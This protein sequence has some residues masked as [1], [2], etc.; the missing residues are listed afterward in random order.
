MPTMKDV[1][2]L[3]GVS[4]GTVSNVLNGS[5]GVSIDKIR[6]VEEAVKAL[7]Y[8]PNALARNLKTSSSGRIDVLLPNVTDAANACLYESIAAAA[9]RDGYGVY[10]QL[11]GDSAEREAENLDRAHMYNTDGVILMTCR[12]ERPEPFLPLVD[13]GL[14]LV[15]VQREI[16]SDDFAF[17][18]LDARAVLSADMQSRLASGVTRMAIVTGPR[19]NSFEAACIDAYCGALFKAGIDVR[20]RNVEAV[21]LSR[22]AAMRAAIRLLACDEPPEIIYC[23]CQTLYDGVRCALTLAGKTKPLPRVVRFDAEDWTRQADTNRL[24]LPYA[25]LGE[26]AFELLREGLETGRRSTRRSIVRARSTA[27]DAPETPV[28]PGK[29]RTLRVLLQDAPS[30]DSVRRFLPDF[31]RQTGI[32]VEVETQPYR[33]VL[34][35]IQTAGG[36]FDVFTYDLAW[37][38]ELALGGY[39]RELTDIF[40][41]EAALQEAFSKDVLREH[42]YFRDRLHAL[43][44]SHTAQLLFYRKD[45]FAELKNQRLYFERNK[46]DLHIPR[47][48][49]TYNRV[50]RFFTKSENPES[51]TTYGTTLGA[52][53]PSGAVCEFLPRAWA[54][55]GALFR[56]GV[57]ALGE[58][59]CVRALTCYQES[60]RY[61]H[62]D[63]PDMWWDEQVA[64][65]ADGD[66]AMMIM[67]TDHTTRLFDR[68]LSRVAGTTGCALL[69]G[70]AS[71]LGGWSVAISTDSRRT[72]EALAFIKWVCAERM[73]IPNAALG[74][75]EPRVSVYGNSA[76][77]A[78]CPYVEKLPEAFAH[79]MRRSLPKGPRGEGVPE[80]RLEE[81]LGDA[82]H[83]TIVGHIDA[84]E[85]L[86]AAARE[87]DGAIHE[88]GK[89][90]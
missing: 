12:P 89:K 2:R 53:N 83:G 24:P 74:R 77:S 56:D 79:A 5:K 82:V 63:S 90:N 68:T 42:C 20:A 16:R 65:F 61:A 67:Y 72:E 52:R 87:L 38:K 45:L 25:A 37:T 13:N 8:K 75:V 28:A 76:L 54:F 44:Y 6:R 62:P 84:R 81:I 14:N 49:E 71:V 86:Q 64:Q 23:T 29:K 18:G 9:A 51:P 35:R 22:E 85:A 50:A 69:P 88:F 7:G 40:P 1:A 31:E 58:D 39:I 80:S 70:K 34:H 36:D 46:E 66:A 48:W 19:D 59:S 33:D 60:F 21:D 10:L 17:A 26:A 15:F 32:S 11:S 73:V 41:G 78:F 55:G 4:H 3:A 57:C 47:D 27:E 30:S 43:P